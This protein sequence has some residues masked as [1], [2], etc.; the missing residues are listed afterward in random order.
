MDPL[1]TAIL[2]GFVAYAIASGLRSRGIAGESLEEFFL[3][4]RSLPGWKAGIS[5]AAT[6]FAADTPMMVTGLIATAGIFSLWRLW[7]YALAFLLMGF[8]LA[9]GWRRAGVL[10]DAELTELRYAGK[11]ALVLRSVKAVYFGT[12]FNCMVLGFVLLAATR[13]AEPFLV[14][15]SWSWFPARVHDRFVAVAHW[16][17]AT[18]AGLSPLAAASGPDLW[19]KAANNLISITAILLVTAFYSTAGGLRS[20][21]NTDVLQFA[22]MMFGTLLF[23]GV[24][25][26]RAG[27]LAALPSQ[28][29]ARFAAGG[30][31][32]IEPTQILAFT[33]GA[34]PRCVPRGAPPVRSPV[35]RSDECGRNRLPGTTLDGLPQRPRRQARRLVVHVRASSCPESRVAAARAWPAPSVPAG[36]IARH[37]AHA[38]RP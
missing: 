23:S 21:V 31:G 16:I 24:V 13:I 33:P 15:D 25:V 2:L 5:M 1:D 9:A 3:A 10:T 32:G 4:G 27:G 12:I 19:D 35:V 8:V 28:I 17:G 11:A 37:R 7:V 26:H 14:W 22:V 34:A 36:S 38:N 6:Q 20:V 30:P 18:P 29:H